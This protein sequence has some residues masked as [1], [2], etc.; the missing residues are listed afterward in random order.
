MNETERNKA[1]VRRV[2]DEVIK[3]RR[4]AVIDEIYDEQVVDHDPLP[5]APPGIEGVRYSIEGLLQ[6]F[7]DLHVTIEDV[8][9]DRDLV[10]VHNTWRGTQSGRLLGML[11]TGRTVTFAGVVIW[12]LENGRITERWALIDL[13]RELGVATRR[14]ATR[15]GEAALNIGST[16]TPLV[17]LQPIASDRYDEWKAFHDEFTERREEFEASRRR[18]GAR[19]EMH[20]LTAWPAVRDMRF[21]VAYYETEDVLRFVEGLATSEE[22]FDVW[23]RQ[24]VRDLHGADWSK[25]AAQGLPS[26]VV[27]EWFAE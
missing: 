5:G 6:G 23:F 8:S 11:S 17:A 20:W 7:P 12:R 14:R 4:L 18:L 10:A 15:G 27:F 16:V 13:V 26:T 2:F 9:A 24:R 19:R 3:E 1:T 22:P 21:N 25:I